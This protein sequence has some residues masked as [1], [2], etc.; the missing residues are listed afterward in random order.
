MEL[1]KWNQWWLCFPHMQ[2]PSICELNHV[3]IET[4]HKGIIL[5]RY[6]I[7]TTLKSP[8]NVAKLYFPSTWKFTIDLT[9]KWEKLWKQKKKTNDYSQKNNKWLIPRK[10][11][12]YCM[13]KLVEKDCVSN[14]NE[15]TKWYNNNIVK[16]NEN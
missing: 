4:L 2:H 6:I 11:N 12:D 16:K 1:D 7:W 5:Y 13:F 10:S 14:E 3:K 8:T 9:T 15:H